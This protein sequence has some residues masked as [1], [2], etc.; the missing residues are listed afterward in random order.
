MDHEELIWDHFK[1]NADQ[2]LKAFNFFLLLSIFANGGVITALD[3][4]MDPF[5][6]VI[7]GIFLILLSVLFWITD[8]RSKG[9]LWLS[10]DALLEIEKKYPDKSQIFRIDRDKRK[11]FIRYTVAIS[12]LLATQLFFGIGVV[13]FGLCEV[14]R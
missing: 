5:L 2:R 4:K 8:A 13:I 7:I 6:L 9:L 12:T 10:V 1:F 11:S 3:K 14:W